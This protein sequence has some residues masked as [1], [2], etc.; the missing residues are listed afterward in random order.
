MTDRRDDHPTY[1][2][3]HDDDRLLAF[4]LG[5]DEDPELAAAAATDA[6]LAAR[7]EAV[8]ADVA[9]VEARVSAA[10][11]PPEQDYTD[12]S[13][14][15]WG[16]LRE[17]FEAPAETGGLRRKRR[18]WRL[19]A[20]VAALVV[21]ALVVGVIAVNGSRSGG[22]NS[23]TGVAGRSA[24]DGAGAPLQGSVASAEAGATPQA[25]GRAALGERF[26]DE[27][28]R[29]AVVVLARARQATGVVQRF[30]VLRVFKG[31][32][33]KVVELVVDDQPTD[34]GRLHLLMLEPTAPP[35]AQS[36]APW[37]PTQSPTAAGQSP[38]PDTA[39]PVPATA[40]PAAV[41]ASPAPIPSV[42]TDGPGKQLAVSYTYDGAPT[43][44]REFPPGTD[45]DSVR[46][47]VP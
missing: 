3:E 26:V 39:S 8:S 21:L 18:P 10:V 40:S 15:R 37:S 22:G 16:G 32:A 5:L 11:P 27:L 38:L 31:S 1:R 25:T 13:A 46:F 34:E 29:F 24:G 9:A 42:A 28:N 33:P 20:S 35:Q 45:P 43:V 44:V 7:L 12:L 14:G 23:F 36:A 2:G 41:T 17:F 19:V 6:E 47:A 4:A 30:T